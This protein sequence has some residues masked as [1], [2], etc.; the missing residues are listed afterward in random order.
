MTENIYGDTRTRSLADLVLEVTEP[1][2]DGVPARAFFDNPDV[3][4]AIGLL[5][6]CRSFLKAACALFDEDLEGP[7]AP[8]ARSSMEYAVTGVWLLNDRPKNLKR[9]LQGHLYE[10]R[11][12]EKEEPE[13]AEQSRRLV[14]ETFGRILDEEERVPIKLPSFEKRLG[15][16]WRSLYVNYRLLCDE[17]H[18]S[19]IASNLS[20]EVTTDEDED[21]TTIFDIE[22]RS[23]GRGESGEHLFFTAAWAVVLAGEIDDVL[24]GGFPEAL[25]AAMHLLHLSINDPEEFTATIRRLDDPSDGA[26]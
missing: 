18:P 7:I 25:D 13:T 21:G 14:L 23:F 3:Y 11:R 16:Q 17:V 4:L 20:Y 8:L 2:G 15:D 26:E 10:A 1:P 19:L 24:G 22:Y 5:Q 12:F 6:G 9:F